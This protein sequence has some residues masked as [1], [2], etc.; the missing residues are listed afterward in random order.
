MKLENFDE[1]KKLVEMKNDIENID[2]TTTHFVISDPAYGGARITLNLSG[3]DDDVDRFAISLKCSILMKL[4]HLG[5]NIEAELQEEPKFV[6]A[7]DVK[8]MDKK[9]TEEMRKR[10]EDEKFINAGEV[11]YPAAAKNE[12]EKLPNVTKAGD[13]CYAGTGK[14]V[15]EI[16]E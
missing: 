1:V 5:V 12:D 16:N 8:D 2:S 10:S 15:T 6:T 3:F 4:K 9:L 13:E 7:T 11:W 14:N